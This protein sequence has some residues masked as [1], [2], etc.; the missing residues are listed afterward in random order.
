[1]RT[2]LLS[3]LVVHRH[4]PLATHLRWTAHMKEKTYETAQKMLF[5]GRA[6]HLAISAICEIPFRM[7]KMAMEKR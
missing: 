3:L 5:L 1:M 6:P 2:G 7:V 4:Y